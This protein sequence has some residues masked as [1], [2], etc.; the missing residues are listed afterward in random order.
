MLEEVMVWLLSMIIVWLYL[1][2]FLIDPI[3]RLFEDD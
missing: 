3:I 2:Y 1:Y